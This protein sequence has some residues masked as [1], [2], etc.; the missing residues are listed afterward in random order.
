MARREMLT[1]VCYD[2]ARGAARR[3]VAA[4]LEDA[5]VRVQKSV[6]EARL[7]AAEADRIAR[8]AAAHLEPGDSLRLY[9]VAADGLPRSRAYGPLPLAEDAD[10]WLL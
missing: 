9:A 6:F 5:M 8:A 1:V 3:R 10:F 7:T 4:V 2:V